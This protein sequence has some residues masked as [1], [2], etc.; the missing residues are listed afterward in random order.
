MFQKILHPILSILL[1]N[2]MLSGS[3]FTYKYLSHLQ[4]TIHLHEN[5][6]EQQEEVEQIEE[7]T[8]A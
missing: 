3:F 4:E 5:S 7:E 2:G 1:A 8:I 6:L